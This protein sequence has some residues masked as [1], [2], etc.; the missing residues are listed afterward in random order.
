MSTKTR[1]LMVDDEPNV[2][3]GYRRSIG[4]NYDLVT[5]NSGR[6][7]L[8]VMN[9][10]GPFEVV[11]TD[12]RMPEM[13]GLEFLKQAKAKHPN[14]VY[15]MLTGN[16]DQQTAIDAI[17]HGHIYRFLN[18][19]CEA[20]ILDHTIRA[21]KSQ[22]DL[23]HAEAEL[24]SNTLSGSVKLLI[25]AM[26]I[27]DPVAAEA[28]RAVREGMTILSNGLGI[29]NEWRFPLASSL[30]LIGSITT[31]R[32]SNKDILNE[33]YINTC[34]RSGAKLLRHISRLD[35]V[36]QI[37]LHQRMKMELPEDLS[38][39][40]DDNRVTIGSQLLRFSYDWYRAAQECNGDRHL[41]LK[42]L[43]SDAG[44]HDRRLF[45]AANAVQGLSIE[46]QEQ[47]PK[48]VLVELPIMDLYQGLLTD[49][50]INTND[51]SL[52]VAKGQTLSQLMIDRL[53]GFYKAGLVSQN[54]SVWIE[55]RDKP[56][57]R[58]LAS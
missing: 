27:S 28:V 10:D 25:E 58:A 7:G 6:E 29:K 44:L 18:K 54:A 45:V 20:E 47:E 19:P 12:M 46:T 15:V 51:G 16:A 1:V 42:R 2:L 39:L 11:I 13:D 17:N 35:L 30:F 53:R 21:C 50:D 52:L 55:E 49:A 56:S 43:A 36:A 23:I 3:S 14:T 33:E 57:D 26:V 34:A 37:I 48:R 40:D 32:K 9:N 24:L 38:K 31:P 41:G 5:A 4:R 22:Y 8:E